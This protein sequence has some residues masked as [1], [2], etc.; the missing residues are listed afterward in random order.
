MPMMPKAL[1]KGY[2]CV[3]RRC[4][5][6]HNTPRSLALLRSALEVSDGVVRSQV[7]AAL[8]TCRYRASAGDIPH[9]EQRLQAEMAEAAWTLAALVDIGQEA[10]VAC[11]HTA[12]SAHFGHI[13]QRLFWLLSFLYDPQAMLRAQDQLTY[14]TPEKRAY[15]LEIIDV[16]VAPP[17]KN[18]L[19]PLLDD[20]SPAQRVQRVQAYCPQT[21]LDLPQRLRDILADVAALLEEITVPA[22]ETILH[23]DDVGRCMYIIVA[24]RV[25]VHNGA[26]LSRV[27]RGTRYCWCVGRFRRGTPLGLRDG[28]G[29]HAPVPARSGGLL[30]V[31]GG[32]F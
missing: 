24:G 7:L 11:L 21:A 4:R 9:I 27:S 20:T 26:Q 14:G 30:G 19:F 22:G 17:L 16:L 3:A 25:R 13:Q 15:A 12:L 6:R 1:R 32:P 8:S 23:K 18:G 2:F 28:R 31:D 10:T 5:S 29:R